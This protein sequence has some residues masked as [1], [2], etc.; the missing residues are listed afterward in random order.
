MSNAECRMPNAQHPMPNTRCLIISKFTQGRLETFK[1]FVDGAADGD[2]EIFC[3]VSNYNWF[4]PF[5][6]RFEQAT[7][8]I[9]TFLLTILIT[10]MY[11]NAR[12]LTVKTSQRLL[13]SI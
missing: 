2:V 3:V 9:R 7:F 6:P 5:Q 12:D 11:L 1:E 4:Q 10:E 8:I 13:D